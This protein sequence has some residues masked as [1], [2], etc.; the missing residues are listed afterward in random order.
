MLKKIILVFGI[1]AMMTYASMPARAN[2]DDTAY[3]LGGVVGGLLLGEV[4]QNNSPRYYYPPPPY[5]YPVYDGPVY[6]GPIYQ[7]Q[8]YTRWVK[9]WSESRQIWV[10][11]RRTVCNWVRVE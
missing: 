5:G 10:R 7:K 1:V 11:K 9:R 4:I 2:N 6:G 8:C 3:F